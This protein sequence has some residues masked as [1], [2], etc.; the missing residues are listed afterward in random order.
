MNGVERKNVLPYE[1][2]DAVLDE[3]VIEEK[4]RVMVDAEEREVKSR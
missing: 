2:S 1:L 4:L 3:N